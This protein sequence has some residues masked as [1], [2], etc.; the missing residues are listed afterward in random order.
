M[1]AFSFYSRALS[2]A[3][4]RSPCCPWLS[5]CT[6]TCRVCRAPRA[7]GKRSLLSA[8]AAAAAGVLEEHRAEM[9]DRLPSNSFMQLRRKNFT[10]MD[11]F[12]WITNPFLKTAATRYPVLVLPKSHPRGLSWQVLHTLSNLFRSRCLD[13]PLSLPGVICQHWKKRMNGVCCF[14]MG[15]LRD[16]MMSTWSHNLVATYT[17]CSFWLYWQYTIVGLY[18]LQWH[19]FSLSVN[20]GHESRWATYCYTP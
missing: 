18:K 4:W 14:L 9:T 20:T 11:L 13:V 5:G 15:Q 19:Q 8:A 6:K 16:E 7:G 2:S 1:K 17:T 3:R 12:C 10:L